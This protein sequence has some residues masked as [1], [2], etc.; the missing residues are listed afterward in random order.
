M[1]D[2]ENKEQKSF[3]AALLDDEKKEQ[4]DFVTNRIIELQ[5]TRQ[6]HYGKNLDA[7]WAEADRDYI[8]HRLKSARSG[9]RIVY[10]DEEKGMRGALVELGSSDWQSDVALANPYVK[11]SVAL[12]TLVDQNP[13]GVFT[14]VN[15]KYQASTVLMEQ[16]YKRSWEYARSK[17]QLKLFVHN[18]G[19]YGWA[20][21]RTYPLRIERTNKVIKTYDPEN[22]EK[23][24]YEEK[25]VVEY[26]DIWRENLDPRNTWID[27]M[28]RPNDEHSLRDWCWR[29]LYPMDTAKMLFGKS[30]YWDYVMKGGNL[31]ETIGITAGQ[32]TGKTIKEQNL[33]EAIF[34]ESLEKDLFMVRLNNVPVIIE[35]LP[36]SDDEGRKRLS[37]WQTYW[38]LRHAESPYGIGLYEAVRYEDGILDRIRNMTIDQLTLSIYKMFFYQST[39]TLKETGD[40]KI[41][42]G[43]GKQVIDPKNITWLDVP[44]PG[45][46]AWKGLEYFKKEVDEVSGISDPLLGVVTGKTAYE[47]AQAKEAALKRLKLPLD[48]ILDALNTEAYITINLAQLI[49][50]VPETYTIE[51]QELIEKYL[52]EV[53]GDQELFSRGESGEFNAQ[54]FREFPLN[55]SQDEK[56]NLV[57]TAETKFFRIKPKYLKWEGIINVK[58]Q[59]I[60]TPTKQLDKTLELEMYNMLIPL[61]VQP[62]EIYK[63]VAENIVK[64]Y[65]KDP[66]DILP[67]AWMMNPEEMMN[68]QNNAEPLFIDQASQFQDRQQ[69]IIKPQGGGQVPPQ[70][71][72]AVSSVSK[73]AN[74]QSVGQRLI[75]RFTG[76]FRGV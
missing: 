57:E 64:L 68:E 70:A 20:C 35:P 65:D 5:Q 60:L 49:Y 21:G 42:P 14:A 6:M 2:K 48:N 17:Q 54:V 76:A 62:P 72:K 71:P 9:K 41:V 52:A 1:A 12:A 13:A 40:I 28:A 10:T 75:S 45:A 29:K 59:S 16:L 46:E 37:L 58:A 11:L 63:K 69:G 74:P 43:L 39:N 19:K 26:N 61:L 56:G 18:L 55:L 7:L 8:P 67:D 44:G 66:K 53:G 22:P 25:K 34:Y 3:T 31:Q 32:Q 4:Y 73:P 24:E 50:S 38:T 36:V 30:K 51:N 15:K 47:A 27:D 23:T 33:V